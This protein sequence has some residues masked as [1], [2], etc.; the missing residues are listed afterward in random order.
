MGTL[1][2]GLERGSAG[3]AT[4]HA[5]G[6]LTMLSV[7]EETG[8]ASAGHVA[9]AFATRLGEAAVP[10]TGPAYP[11]TG[12]ADG[13]VGVAHAMRRFAAT[14]ADV[15]SAPVPQSIVGDN[16]GWCTGVSGMVLAGADCLDLA[17]VD[18][19]VAA[20]ARRQPLR[21]ASLCHGE[22]GI[23]EAL[24]VLARRGHAG[25]A[26][27]RVRYAARAVGA[28]DR[29]GPR[30]GTPNG[31]PSPG[32]LTGL[33]GIGYGLLRLGFADQVPS[34]LLLEPTFPAR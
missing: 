12:F 28:L 23:A 3:I 11:P 20:L 18:D 30:C 9:A 4:G 1:A 34:V 33:A 15:P 27:T 13:A 17:T 8:L 22:L 29:Y 2:D 16:F 7:H 5:G 24:S 19:A 31:V 25:A 6:L 21:D 32:L 10:G 26:E 14:G